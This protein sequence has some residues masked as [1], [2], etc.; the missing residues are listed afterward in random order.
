MRLYVCTSYSARLYLVPTKYVMA[1][2]IITSIILIILTSVI[3]EPY[4][5][6]CGRIRR[7]TSLC[8]QVVA[9][10]HRSLQEEVMPDPVFNAEL[11]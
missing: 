5:S 10:G 3:S 8:L 4:R 6:C 7:D 1:A 9:G 2:I 11:G